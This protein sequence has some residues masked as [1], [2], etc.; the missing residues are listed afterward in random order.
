MTIPQGC[1]TIIHTMDMIILLHTTTNGT[2]DFIYGAEGIMGIN[3][4]GAVYLFRKNVF[5][6]VTHIYDTEGKLK[7]R[8]TYD[9]LDRLISESM[10]NTI[11][12]QKF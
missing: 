8:Y 1:A 12:A 11:K 3:Y 6:D 10:A 5:G 7:A 4:N 9:K 2:I